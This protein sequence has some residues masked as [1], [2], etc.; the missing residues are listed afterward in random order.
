MQE[1][2]KRGREGEE[3]SLFSRNNKRIDE[4]IDPICFQFIPEGKDVGDKLLA[5]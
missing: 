5:L 1:S 2:K 3:R 4:W